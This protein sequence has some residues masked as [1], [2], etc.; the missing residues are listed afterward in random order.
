ML[1]GSAV[2]RAFAGRLVGVLLVCWVRAGPVQG[3]SEPRASR[4]CG[5]ASYAHAV[6][7][8]VRHSLSCAWRQWSLHR[9]WSASHSIEIRVTVQLQYSCSWDS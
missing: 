9:H 4:A 7:W 6:P 1:Y 3:G 2:R 8:P 5:G